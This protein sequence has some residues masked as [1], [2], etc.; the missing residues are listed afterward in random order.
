MFKIKIKVWGEKNGLVQVRVNY[1]DFI[2]MAILFSWQKY[3]SRLSSIPDIPRLCN[4]GI[5]L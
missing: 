4:I 1:S 2:D 5:F 3:V